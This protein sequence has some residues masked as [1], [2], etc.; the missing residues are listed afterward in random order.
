M[1]D[2]STE[3]RDSWNRVQFNVRLTEQRRD[4]LLAISAGM[5]KASPVDAIDY[6]IAV[7]MA[8]RKVAESMGD[9]L[10]QLS[11]MVESLASVTR[12]GFT[13]SSMAQ[14]SLQADISHVV[15]LM[16]AM[17][18]VQNGYQATDGDQSS[19]SI[20]EWLDSQHLETGASAILARAKWQSSEREATKLA[21]MVLLVERM[22]VGGANKVHK[23]TIPMMV[24][25]VNIDVEQNLFKAMAHEYFY[26][27][28]QRMEKRG[29]SISAHVIKEDKSI[30]QAI[31]ALQI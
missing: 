25:I 9:Q 28:C 29:W 11:S 15:D 20:S 21:C 8:D 12:Q 10:A 18:G 4:R 2:E 23:P 24:R 17:A 19:M 16:S 7:A 31:A 30:G 22:A 27:A 1:D 13:E 5:P 26:L 6:C 3:L 14:K